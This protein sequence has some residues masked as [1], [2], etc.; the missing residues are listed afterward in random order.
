MFFA[1]WNSLEY[2]IYKT[3][4]NRNGRYIPEP[5]KQKQELFY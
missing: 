2:M 5:Y 4:E 3:K 1:V